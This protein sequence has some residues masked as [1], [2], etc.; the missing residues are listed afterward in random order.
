MIS[1]GAEAG[2][3]DGFSRVSPRWFQNE[4]RVILSKIWLYL[5]Y[6]MMREGYMR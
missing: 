1:G 5:E 3:H 6:M 4:V 2:A